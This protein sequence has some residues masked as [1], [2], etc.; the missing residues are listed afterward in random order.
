MSRLRFKPLSNP[1]LFISDCPESLTGLARI[2]R[3]LAS[4]VCRHVPEFRVA[5]L[6]RGGVGRRKFPWTSYSFPETAQWGEEYLETCWKDFSGGEDGVVMSLWDLSRM[7]W[8]S[9]PEYSGSPALVQFLGPDRNFLKWGYTPIDST[10]PGESCLPIQLAATAQGY[11]RL[12]AASQ[13]GKE[14]LDWHRT[15]A[16]YIP[17]GIW[18]GENAF[19]I[20]ARAAEPLWAS[21]TIYVGCVMT[22][23]PRKDWPVAFECARFLMKEYGNKIRFWFHTDS[24]DRYWNFDALAA[25]YGVE[26]KVDVTL[27][28]RDEALA[29][30][31][32]QCAAT[33]LPTGGEGFGYPIAESFACGT[34]C[35][36]TDYAAGQCL[37]PNPEHKVLP[38]SLRCDTQYNVLRA[39]NH[40][41]MFAEKAGRAIETKLLDWDEEA[42][43]HRQ[44][45]EHLD[46]EKLKHVWCRWFREG[47]MERFV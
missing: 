38:L 32:S 44:S 11:D 5:Y 41:G 13:W 40:G 17:H 26:G 16:D 35:I 45:V 22:N 2:G 15:D 27:A 4:L 34:A 6:G 18:M 43:K 1:L 3:D 8:F 39:V 19:R 37:V 7:L 42:K 9:R 46:W 28:M 21:P 20:H 23:Q 29:Y 25:D 14:V 31:Y 33:I 12:I 36:T 30:H 10:G 24:K 47:L